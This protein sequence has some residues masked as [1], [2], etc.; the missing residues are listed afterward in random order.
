[1]K[2]DKSLRSWVVPLLFLCAAGA[3]L[4]VRA[5]VGGT[6]KPP[7]AGA[8]NGAAKA[9]ASLEP[10]L[11]QASEAL[12]AGQIQAAREA[13]ADAVTLDPRNAKATHGLALCLLYSKETRKAC[14]TFDKAINLSPKPDRALVLNAAAAHSADRNNARTAKL[15]K[16]Y[17][18]ANPKE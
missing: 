17:L 3:A 8:A 6:A 12:D 5:Q 4:P 11:K 13:F 14:M 2:W 10:L 1:M 16:D 9:K 7:A 15:I 18:T